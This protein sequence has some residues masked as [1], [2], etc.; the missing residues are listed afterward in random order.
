MGILGKA[1]DAEVLRTPASFACSLRMSFRLI[2]LGNLT[3]H[4]MLKMPPH[5]CSSQAH[6]R[7]AGG[8]PDQISDGASTTSKPDR[9]LPFFPRCQHMI[10]FRRSFICI[11][12][13]L[14]HYFYGLPNGSLLFFY[15]VVNFRAV[16]MSVN[17]PLVTLSEV[18]STPLSF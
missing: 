1:A 7:E 3:P 15:Q 2:S 17:L 4:S 13:L 16:L 10:H 5:Q 11:L 8:E 9:Q 18:G 6:N 14:S 12:I